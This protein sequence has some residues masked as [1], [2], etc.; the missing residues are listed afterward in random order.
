M[1]YVYGNVEKNEI[2]KNYKI[3][4]NKIIVTYLDGS[5][6]EFDLSRE[7]ELLDIMMRQAIE[8]NDGVIDDL[9]NIH[10]DSSGN[11]ILWVIITMYSSGLAVELANRYKE[12]G[13]LVM[14]IIVSIPFIFS[15]RKYKNLKDELIKYNIYLSMYEKLE[16][17]EKAELFKGIKTDENIL[18]INTLD[19]YSL[20]D[21]KTIKNNLEKYETNGKV[22]TKKLG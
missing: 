8:R 2:I 21:I 17:M 14:P 4:D 13:V 15:G 1:K 19:N 20:K 12:F 9:D 3:V 18:N 16:K 5:N 11:A 6:L 7:N 10:A 22:L